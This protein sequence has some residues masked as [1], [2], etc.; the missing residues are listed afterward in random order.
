MA[1]R[2]HVVCSV[3]LSVPLFPMYLLVDLSVSMRLVVCI[4]ETMV[5]VRAMAHGVSG[6]CS[7]VGTSVVYSMV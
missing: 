1:R 5:S 3:E 7:T 4:L 6:R 2:R